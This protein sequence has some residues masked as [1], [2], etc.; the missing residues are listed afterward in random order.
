MTSKELS[1]SDKVISFE[2]KDAERRKRFNFTRLTILIFIFVFIRGPLFQ[3]EDLT[4]LGWNRVSSWKV[5]SYLVK[6]GILEKFDRKSYGVTDNAHKWFRRAFGGGANDAAFAYSAMEAE[7]WSELRL[8]NFKSDLT[9]MW[10]DRPERF[11]ND[12]SRCGITDGEEDCAMLMKLLYEKLDEVQ[13]LASIIEK[14]AGFSQ[15][16]LKVA[17]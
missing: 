14:K 1:Q 10:L 7:T 8:N 11:N 17:S 5:L 13:T 12:P 15:K 3:V 16:N 2:E 4:R 6:A 9:R